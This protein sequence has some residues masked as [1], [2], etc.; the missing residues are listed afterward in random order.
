MSRHNG[1]ISKEEEA[2][3]D[4]QIRL[5]GMEAQSRLRNSSIL[6]VGVKAVTLEACKNLVLGG[7]GRLF[8]Y[9]PQPIARLDLETQYYFSESHVG[10]AKDKVLA[11]KLAVLN[12]LVDIRVASSLDDIDGVDLVVSIGR[13][14][15]KDEWRQRGIKSILADAFGLFG[16][17][18]VDCLDAHEYIEESR[19]R[20]A[21]T[22]E[23]EVVRE[24]KVA[25]YKSFEESVKAKVPGGSATRL[26]RKYSP[27][28]LVCQ[29]LATMGDEA[30]VGQF[31]KNALEQR[32]LPQGY[33]E[34][35][36]LE[37][38]QAS[39]DTE[40]V[41]SAAVVGATLAQE[42]LKIITL[43]D[44]PANNWFTYDGLVSEGITCIL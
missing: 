11:E 16:Y 2:L 20:D 5:W 8:I 4:R 22:G 12:P 24:S 15:T 19:V 35:E 43:K 44:M 37:R 13:Q 18:F 42:A 38:V 30:A 28:V 14:Q 39:W 25:T 7:I 41:P 1:V 23:L 31:V 17:I 21:K 3:Y 26:A 9:D 34:D 32:E 10:Q 40:F 6:F 33:V 29:A 36:L 27:L